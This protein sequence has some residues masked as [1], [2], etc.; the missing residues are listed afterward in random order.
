MWKFLR[1]S[2]WTSLVVGALIALLRLT[3]IRWWQVPLGDPYL[4]ASLAPSLQGG[5]WIV[6][7][8][9]TQPTE[10]DLVLCPEPKAPTRPVIARMLGEGNDHIKFEGSA[11]RVNRNAFD[12]ESGC[13]KFTVRDPASGQE[14]EQSCRHELVGNKT[15]L[16]GELSEAASKPSDAEFD[17]PHGQ[18]FLI[19]DNRQFPWDSRDFGAVSRETCTETVIFRLVSKNGFFDVAHRLMLIR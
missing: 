6:L 17:V 4:E 18:I 14:V 3:A 19:S 7:W 9:A 1:W 16:R 2:A 13:D 11:V 8:R 10:G 5:D 15:H 12:S